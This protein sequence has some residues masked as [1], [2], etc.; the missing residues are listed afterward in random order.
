MKAL[1]AFA[2]GLYMIAAFMAASAGLDYMIEGFG[3][4]PW[5][6]FPVAAACAGMSY[7]TAHIASLI[8][9]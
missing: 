8:D 4:I 3:L 2:S 5:L 9:P 6:A 1:L 7:F